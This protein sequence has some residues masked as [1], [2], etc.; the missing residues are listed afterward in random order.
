MA[1]SDTLWKEI[2]NLPIEMFSLPN[3]VVGMH[4]DRLAGTGNEVYLKLKSPAA[5]PA[6]ETTLL[7]QRVVRKEKRHDRPHAEP[8]TVNVSYPKYDIKEN[9]GGYVVVTR[10]VPPPDRDE[11][12]KVTG[13][14]FVSGQEEAAQE[15]EPPAPAP[16]K[17]K[18]R[19]RRTR[20]KKEES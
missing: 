12:Q 19:T 7:A 17:K 6:L 14:F 16:V 20:A 15:P 4:V 11:L 1:K 3:Q 5:L 13:E 8:E 9:E 18:T 10:H 2:E